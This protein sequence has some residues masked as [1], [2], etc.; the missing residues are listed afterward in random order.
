MSDPQQPSTPPGWYPDGQGSQRWWDG[1]RWTD[2]VQPAAPPIS[3]A[4][5][6]APPAPAATGF[7]PNQT[8][9]APPRGGQTPPGA[10]PGTPPGTPQGAPQGTP[11][12]TPWGAPPWQA[13]YAGTQGRGRGKGA[14]IGV[15]AGIAVLAVVG[16][17]VLFTVVLGGSG[18]ADVAEDYLEAQSA[19][20]Q[21]RVCELS[22]TRSRGEAFEGFEVDTCAAFAKAIEDQEGY[23][24]FAGLV[25]DIDVDIEIG[26]VE[27]QDDSATVDYTEEVVYTGDDAGLFTETFGE[28]DTELTVTG[29]ITLVKQDGDWFVDEDEDTT[30]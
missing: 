30:E 7:D 24:V 18:P 13:P 25:E 28:E 21:E 15:V 6:A 20:E 5:P 22:S 1:V 2:H 23:D 9:V 29:T 16:L 27:E 26:A 14:V 17:V 4:E 11:L 19:G 10:A 12:G 8:V 3:P